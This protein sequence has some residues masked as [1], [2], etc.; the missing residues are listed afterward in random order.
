[1]VCRNFILRKKRALT[2]IKNGYQIP[3]TNTKK[4]SS[5]RND[6]TEEDN[7]SSNESNMLQGMNHIDD[8]VDTLFDK[9]TDFKTS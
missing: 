4:G 8:Y 7:D 6:I 5:K 9:Q 3:K 1:M 2:G